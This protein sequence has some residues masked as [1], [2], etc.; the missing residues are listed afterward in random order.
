MII[1]K[2]VLRPGSI[3]RRYEKAFIAAVHGFGEKSLA[4]ILKS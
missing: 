2:V 4:K 1:R 3:G